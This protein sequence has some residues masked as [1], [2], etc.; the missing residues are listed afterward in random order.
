MEDL[1]HADGVVAWQVG[2]AK[3]ND[4]HS[5]TMLFEELRNRR[6]VAPN[7]SEI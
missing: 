1:A 3:R 7:F 5:L 6:E 2:S 4:A